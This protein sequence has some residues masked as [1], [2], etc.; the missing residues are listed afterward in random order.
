MSRMSAGAATEAVGRAAVA[1]ALG[2]ERQRQE[3]LVVL[4]VEIYRFAETILGPRTVASRLADHPQQIID[5]GIG[6]FRRMCCSHAAIASACRP[7]LARS[8][9]LLQETPIG[10]PSVETAAGSG[11]PAPSDGRDSGGVGRP[12]PS[13]E[14]RHIGG[15]GS[16]RAAEGHR[17]HRLAIR[18][19]SR[20]ADRGESRRFAGRFEAVGVADE[21]HAVR[22]Q[23][24]VER[25]EHAGAGRGVEIDQQVAAE[26][27][28]VGGAPR[29]AS[30]RPRW[31]GGSGPSLGSRGRPQ[32]PGHACGRFRPG[33]QAHSRGKRWPNNPMPGE[34]QP[35]PL[36]STASIRNR[37]AGR[38]AS[39]SVMA[40]E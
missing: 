38:P 14:L 37:R 40:I 23:Q 24:A 5:R 31:P 25:G 19:A 39:R 27:H 26:H 17:R 15:R 16:G 12:A 34:G 2:Q 20:L 3:R 36:T 10:R 8:R 28:V 32:S 21:E 22:G 35:S 11:R 7:R 13:D 18:E 29:A 6:P 9:G 30:G 4:R 33:A 1:T